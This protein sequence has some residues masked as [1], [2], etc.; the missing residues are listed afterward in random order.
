MLFLTFVY[1]KVELVE[2]ESTSQLPSHKRLYKLSK[3]A[4]ANATVFGT[5]SFLRNEENWGMTGGHLFATTWF[6]DTKKQV[7]RLF[8]S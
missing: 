8:C 5:T 2:V 4:M 6:H 3:C 7:T 1:E